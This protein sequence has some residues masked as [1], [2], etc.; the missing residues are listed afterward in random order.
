MTNPPFPLTEEL[1]L[2]T[3]RPI[4]RYR[5]RR[6]MEFSDTDMAGIVHFAAFFIFMETAEHELRSF[7]G[8][9][10][11]TELQGQRVGWPRVSA[12]CEYIRPVWFGDE[13]DILV[14]VKRKGTKSI[15][16][17]FTFTKGDELIGRGE[18]ASVCCLVDDTGQPT[19]IPMPAFFADQLAEA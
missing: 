15:T 18:M 14:E 19:S 13:L 7:L 4:R 11:H 12:S 1:K 3:E 6:R 2:G 17:G 10:V 16:F 9:E 8:M 5:T